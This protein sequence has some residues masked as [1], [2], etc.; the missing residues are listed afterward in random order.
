MVRIIW[1]AFLLA[2]AYAIGSWLWAWYGAADGL[3]SLM[4]LYTQ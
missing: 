1:I 4:R 2:C 3:F